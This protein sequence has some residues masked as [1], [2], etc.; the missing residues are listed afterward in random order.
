[1]D[2]QEREPSPIHA[3]LVSWSNTSA[4]FLAFAACPILYT[5]NVG[6]QVIVRF[7]MS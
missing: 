5:I 2:S 3:F 1:M 7:M 4:S 6:W